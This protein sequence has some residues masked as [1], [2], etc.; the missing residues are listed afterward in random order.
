MAD[1]YVSNLTSYAKASCWSCPPPG[2]ACP[3]SAAACING[4]CTLVP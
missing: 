1:S 2:G 4:A 3:P